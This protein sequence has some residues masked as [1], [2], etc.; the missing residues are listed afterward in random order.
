MRNL[1]T[2]SGS[3]ATA[4]KL[5]AELGVNQATVRRAAEFAKAVDKVKE[6]APEAADKILAGAELA[7]TEA[8]PIGLSSGQKETKAGPPAVRLRQGL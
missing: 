7:H 2:F 8:T 3:A 1:R 6:V 5:A 4:K